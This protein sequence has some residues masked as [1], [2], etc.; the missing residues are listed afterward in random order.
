VPTSHGLCE[1]DFYMSKESMLL[2]GKTHL[3][4]LLQEIPLGEGEP[5]TVE[6]GVGA[7][8]KLLSKLTDVPTLA[9]PT[10]RQIGTELVQ[11]TSLR[12][13]LPA[14]DCNDAAVRLSHILLRSSPGGANDKSRWRSSRDIVVRNRIDQRTGSC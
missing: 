12:P 14:P 3:L 6:D 8:E 7:F 9:G 11:I 5:A 4:R 10:P 1:V 13:A 2:E